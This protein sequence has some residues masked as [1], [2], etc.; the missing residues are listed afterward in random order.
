MKTLQLFT[1]VF[2]FATTLF[3]QDSVVIH[4]GNGPVLAEFKSQDK[5]VIF[6]RLSTAQ[7][8]GITSPV[9]GL[10]VY[11]TDVKKFMYYDGTNWMSLSNPIDANTLDKAYDQGNPGLGRTI[12]ADQGAVEVAG[13]GANTAFK[14][15]NSGG[16]HG[17][18]VEMTGAGEGIELTHSGTGDAMHIM[19]TGTGNSIDIEHNTQNSAVYIDNDGDAHGIYIDNADGFD[20]AISI[21]SGN[22]HGLEITKDANRAGNGIRINQFGMDAG[23]YVLSNGD[24]EGIH[25]RQL[26]AEQGIVVE[27][28]AMNS[29]NG[30]YFHA[31]NAF[32]DA[33][34][35]KAST[36]GKGTVADFRNTNAANTKPVLEVQQ[37]SST[38]A[39]GR[40]VIN[41]NQSI[42]HA[43]S[44]E[45]LDGNGNAGNFKVNDQLATGHAVSAH[46]IGKGDAGKFVVDNSISTG[47]A[48]QGIVTKGDGYAGKFVMEDINGD[49]GALYAETKGQ[50]ISHAGHFSVSDPNAAGHSILAVNKGLAA[51]G[52]FVVDNNSSLGH[53]ID[54][55]ITNGDGNAGNFVIE[56]VTGSGHAVYAETKGAF[57]GG[58][59][60]F[61][62]TSGISADATVQ[63]QNL[64]Y[65][66]GLIIDQSTNELADE[67]LMIK[68]K[69][70]TNAALFVEQNGIGLTAPGMHI[71]VDNKSNGM[72]LLKSNEGTGMYLSKSDI[73]TGMYLNKTDEGNGIYVLHEDPQTNTSAV[74]AKSIHDWGVNGESDSEDFFKAG[75]RGVG[76]SD[77]DKAA[78]LEIHDGAIRV[79]GPSRPAGKLAVAVSW[80]D[81]IDSAGDIIGW[82]ATATV[83]NNLIDAARSIILVTTE[84]MGRP[85]S[86]TITTV[87]DGSFLLKFGAL[88]ANQPG[89]AVGLHYL[90][91]NE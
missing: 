11:D 17:V 70:S 23:L 19:Q 39:G 91:I 31:S 67:G 82:E 58:S 41:K 84:E 87:Y 47:N 14:V 77:K 16:S 36:V 38:G 54:A 79:S 21:A 32:H 37:Q 57:N 12:T 4:N 15:T 51:A 43:V 53:G 90:I 9:A 5:G 20:A 80:S 72:Q 59:A 22:Q 3:S 49:A 6:P 2:L 45:I 63:V 85:I 62:K 83:S 24:K 88:G 46:T 52:R 50:G 44:A 75:L 40:F 78:A 33:E 65:G 61:F 13:T 18:D 56:D 74:S 10:L 66:P 71:N 8:T 68:S 30:A 73:G 76:M 48:V 29:G 81:I 55:E 89:G 42:G 26:G 27:A 60:A 86:A 1:L 64:G 7:R 35:L 69:S 34:V 28:A 25:V